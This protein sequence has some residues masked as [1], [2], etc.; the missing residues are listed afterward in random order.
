MLASC[1][2]KTADALVD[3]NNEFVIDV[4]MDEFNALSDIFTMVEE[5]FDETDED[6]IIEVFYDEV[7]PQ[8]K[9]LYDLVIDY[10]VEDE[11]VKELHEILIETEEY[12]LG[13]LE[14]MEESLPE[15]DDEM[16]EAYIDKMIQSEESFDKFM[17]RLNDLIDEYGLEEIDD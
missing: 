6:Q 2:N 14:I 5:V 4:Y 9:K 12:R 1:S 8:S 11:V 3:Y 17:N 13:A 7:I 15:L 10:E 16:M